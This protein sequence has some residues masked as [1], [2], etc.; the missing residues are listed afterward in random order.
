MA[1]LVVVVALARRS[2]KEKSRKES[3]G[4][5]PFLRGATAFFLP[6]YFF[7]TNPSYTFLLRSKKSM[8]KF[9][10]GDSA[11]TPLKKRSDR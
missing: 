8:K 1:D 9:A 2:T 3:S 6:F 5:S 4:R 11:D 10:V 7:K